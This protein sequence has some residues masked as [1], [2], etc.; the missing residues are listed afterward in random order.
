M[1]IKSVTNNNLLIEDQR[2]KENVNKIIRNTFEGF[3]CCQKILEVLIERLK[4]EKSSKYNIN[5]VKIL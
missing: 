1:I 3:V 2:Y 5:N 4:S